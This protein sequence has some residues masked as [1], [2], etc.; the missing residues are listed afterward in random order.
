M[1]KRQQKSLIVNVG[2][3]LGRVHVSYSAI[4]CGS[5]SFLEAF[6]SCINKEGHNIDVTHIGVGRVET[7]MNKGYEFG[8]LEVGNFV[9][10]A[11]RQF[12]NYHY[13]EGHWYFAFEQYLIRQSLLA[14]LITKYFD[15]LRRKRMDNEQKEKEK[16]KKKD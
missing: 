9:R 5:K 8:K 11:I 13:T 1:N 10:N 15:Y 16:E 12:G 14:P 7:N 4:Y 6:S 2:S 3:G